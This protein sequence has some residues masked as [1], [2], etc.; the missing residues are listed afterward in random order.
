M[1]ERVDRAGGSGEDPEPEHGGADGGDHEHGFGTAVCSPPR[2]ADGAMLPAA[3][4]WTNPSSAEP[5][6]SAGD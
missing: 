4:H 2:P 1:T 6:P 3:T 5:V